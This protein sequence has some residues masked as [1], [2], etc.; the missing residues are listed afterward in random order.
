[1]AA[2]AMQ[3]QNEELCSFTLHE[4]GTYHFNIENAIRQHEGNISVLDYNQR[5]NPNIDIIADELDSIKRSTTATPDNLD[6]LNEEVYQIRQYVE[7]IS[8]N[9]NTYLE[10]SQEE[11]K[12]NNT[13][14]KTETW[15]TIIN[16]IL[17]LL[18]I[19][20]TIIGLAL[21]L[22]SIG[23]VVYIYLRTRKDTNNQITQ[24]HI[25]TERQITQQYELSKKQ[26]NKMQEHADERTKALT[27]LGN[28]IQAST[29]QIRISVENL[30][31]KFL[32]ERNKSRIDNPY[33]SVI[34]NY[35]SLCK[36]LEREYDHFIKNSNN[37]IIHQ[38][39]SRIQENI[40]RI[41]QILS[42]YSTECEIPDPNAY[43]N[44][45]DEIVN[46][47]CLQKKREQI[48][49]FKYEG[50]KYNDL[51]KNCIQNILYN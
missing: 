6:T 40:R 8:N 31:Q 41:N 16:L 4:M 39:A 50:Q 49:T 44:S 10:E 45:M 13:Q 24:Q 51:L 21:S 33:L 28:Q 19:R 29:G 25:D 18:S 42:S 22:L 5:L 17:S 2:S 7:S 48:N 30:E 27:D 36:D 12:R 15:F 34:S 26:I 11:A 38:R 23:A 37:S 46:K 47:P 35:E 9:T 32:T 1:M 43:L 14:Y 20:L 3:G